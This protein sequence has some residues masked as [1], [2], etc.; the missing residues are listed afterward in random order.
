M[1]DMMSYLLAPIWTPWDMS[2][3]MVDST[4]NDPSQLKTCLYFFKCPVVRLLRN[5]DS[6]LIVIEQNYFNLKRY[7]LTSFNSYW[8]ICKTNTS[9]YLK[10]FIIAIVLICF[11]LWKP[12]KVCHGFKVITW[13][14]II[15]Y[16]KT[17]QKY[18]IPLFQ[19]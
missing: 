10:V 4:S 17:L 9:I 2:V 18:K 1:K 13:F 7:N 3:S 16:L 6:K 11:L 19:W 14:Q 8:Q 12:G 5:N 15:R